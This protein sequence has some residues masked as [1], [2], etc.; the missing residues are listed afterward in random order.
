M[1]FNRKFTLYTNWIKGT[2]KSQNYHID[3]SNFK[4]KLTVKYTGPTGKA[5]KRKQVQLYF[6]V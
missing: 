4:L 2:L 3:L 6:K 1:F 5:K